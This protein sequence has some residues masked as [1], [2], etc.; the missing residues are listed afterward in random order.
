MACL[1]GRMGV[2]KGSPRAVT[3]EVSYLAEK[4]AA[5]SDL[6]H[7][8]FVLVWKISESRASILLMSRTFERSE[9]QGTCLA[10]S[11]DVILLL[12]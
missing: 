12:D 9:A 1:L 5:L 6:L 2:S 4:L 8:Y 3:V 10:I 11:A 7:H